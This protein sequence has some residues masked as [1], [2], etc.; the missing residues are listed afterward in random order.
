VLPELARAYI[1]RG[2]RRPGM[3]VAGDAVDVAFAGIGWGWGGR[4]DSLK[5]Y[6]HF[7]LNNR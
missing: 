7:A 5:D 3:I 2:N 4:W 1:D 6:Q